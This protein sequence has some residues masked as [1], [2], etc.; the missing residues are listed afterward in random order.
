[1]SLPTLGRR[2]F[3]AASLATTLAP[4][5]ASA[6][7]RVEAKRKY[8][9]GLVTYNVAQSWDLS[10]LLKNAQAAGIAAIECRTTHKHGVEPTLN[11]EQRATVK[12]QFA[13]AG[14]VFWGSGSVAEFH[15]EKPEVVEKNI[16]DCKKFLQLVKDLGG[17]GVKVRPNGVVKGKTLEASIEQIGKALK[18]C[19]DAAKNLGLEIWVEVHGPVTAAPK[20]MKAILEVAD[21]PSV[22]VTW[23]SNATD[24]VDKSIASGFE[25]LSK[26]IKSCHINDLNNDK[27]GTYP[28]R[29]LFQRL[30]TLGYD[31]YTLIE[32]GQSIEADKGIEFLKAYKTQWEKLTAGEM[33]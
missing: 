5:L 28:Y 17:R 30:N 32:V 24:L 9:L 26:S 10:T 7:T 4:T 31:R 8:Q 11:A 33:G 23:N 6:T 14:I 18:P 25:M 13:D 16:E 27:K 29:D 20:N 19:G 12:K 3:L 2:E 15:S 22:G 1:M 21:H